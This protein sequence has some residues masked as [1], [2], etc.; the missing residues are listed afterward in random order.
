MARELVLILQG[1]VNTRVQTPSTKE[2]SWDF[3]NL[4]KKAL[5]Q[6]L[7]NLLNF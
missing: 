2:R 7:I 6:E 1:I 5:Q 4:A 3:Q